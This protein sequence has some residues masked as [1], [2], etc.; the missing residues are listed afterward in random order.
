[1]VCAMVI[2]HIARHTSSLYLLL[3]LEAHRRDAITIFVTQRIRAVSM[4]GVSDI[5]VYRFQAGDP[6]GAWRYSIAL[7]SQQLS[8]SKCSRRVERKS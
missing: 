3:K 8:Q 5:L 7:S 4:K 2:R 6:G 1:M